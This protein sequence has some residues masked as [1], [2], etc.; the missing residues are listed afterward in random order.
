MFQKR[1][2]SC[3]QAVDVNRGCMVSFMK[4]L[5]NAYRELRIEKGVYLLDS[6]LLFHFFERV[7]SFSQLFYDK[8]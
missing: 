3:I 7:F 4:L 2:G 1:Y 6:I 5:R 8:K